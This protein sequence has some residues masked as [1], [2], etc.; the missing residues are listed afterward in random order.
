MMKGRL[1]LVQQ[2][3][4]S[5]CVL[6]FF[7]CILQSVRKVLQLPLEVGGQALPTLRNVLQKVIATL[8]L[9]LKKK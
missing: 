2:V 8:D 4:A 5:R 3:V 6:Q 7:P 1:Y 9:P